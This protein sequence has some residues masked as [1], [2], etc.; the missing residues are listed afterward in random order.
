MNC[1]TLFAALTALN[2]SPFFTRG[3]PLENWS[4]LSITEKSQKFTGYE[5]HTEEHIEF[6]FNAF[7]EN[8]KG[9]F[10][11]SLNLSEVPSHDKTKLNP[12][13]FMIDLYN[14]YATDK[15]SIP[16]SNIVRSFNTEEII[17]M[18]P[19]E[20]TTIEKYILLFNVSIPRYEETTRAE[21]RLH[22]SCPSDVGGVP[23][24]KSKITI[25]DVMN[26]DFWDTQKRPRPFLASAEIK[27]NGWEM[28]EVTDAIKRWARFSNGK[29]KNKLE[30]IV[31]RNIPNHF[32]HSKLSRCVTP[33]TKNLPLLIVFSDD[34]SNGT[35]ESR[36]ELREMI[37]H[38]Q[39]IVLKNM[40]KNS[41]ANE[42]E[43]KRDIEEI[44]S[45]GIHQSSSRS[46]RS[47]ATNHCQKTSL[48]VNFKDIGW[49][50]WIIAPK[51]YDAFECKGVCFFPL[52]DVVTPTKHAIVQTLMHLKNPKK[53]AKA[54]CV[55]TKLDSISI[56]YKDDAG[57][58]TLK[59]HYEGMKVAECGC[60]EGCVNDP[61]DDEQMCD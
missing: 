22:I 20:E 41:T 25:Y 28:F 38:E 15:S 59:Y 51:D 5:G 61:H 40:V 33:E 56:L 12:P 52:T 32:D 19:P 4:T 53:A 39:E 57:I 35:K 60:S 43:D 50:S 30:V 54:C 3:K 47:V 31:E 42:K 18:I 48:R 34:Q 29:T 11:R 24:L 17:S 49:D 9:D 16:A 1:I 58:P 13:Q 27:R 14:R 2:F 37:V 10:L 55:P 45:S 23:G 6:D 21:L 7:V 36:V 8:M 44:S 46:K 26:E